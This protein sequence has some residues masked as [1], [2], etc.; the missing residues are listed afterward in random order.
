MANRF[1]LFITNYAWWKGVLLLSKLENLTGLSWSWQQYRN[2]YIELNLSYIVVTSLTANN[3]IYTCVIW[4]LF[5]NNWKPQNPCSYLKDIWCHPLYCMYML[6]RRLQRVLR[7][8]KFCYC[9]SKDA[10]KKRT[11]KYN[12]KDSLQ[13]LMMIMMEDFIMI[14]GCLGC[15]MSLQTFCIHTRNSHHII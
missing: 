2:Q 3:I 5:E 9:W 4:Y 11:D 15:Y 13:D 14:N 1:P 8:H 12:L 6:V 10:S 7:F